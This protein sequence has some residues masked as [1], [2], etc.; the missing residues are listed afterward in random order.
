[1]TISVHVDGPPRPPTRPVAG[2]HYALPLSEAPL[3]NWIA[4][5]DA[6]WTGAR[7]LTQAPLVDGPSK[8][9]LLGLDLSDEDAAAEALDLVVALVDETTERVNQ[10]E[11]AA[12]Y[13][14][15]PDD[16]QAGE[17]GGFLDRWWE[18]REKD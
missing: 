5:F 7:G 16:E 4:L 15:A 3:A 10:R 14:V 2:Y 17:V 9:I 13:G 1:M 12:A 6:H 11:V 8:E 18:R